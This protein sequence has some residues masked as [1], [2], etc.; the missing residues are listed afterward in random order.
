V[1]PL[2]GSAHRLGRGPHP[3][4]HGPAP[5][6]QGRLIGPGP[7]LQVLP[8]SSHFLHPALHDGPEKFPQGVFGLLGNAGQGTHLL[9]H[10]LHGRVIGPGAGFAPLQHGV[11]QGQLLGDR[12]HFL[13]VLETLADLGADGLF[14]VADVDIIFPQSP[15]IE[16]EDTVHQGLEGLAGVFAHQHRLVPGHVRQ[17]RNLF[18]GQA[19]GQKD[20]HRAHGLLG[21]DAQLFEG[22]HEIIQ[23]LPADP[24]I[25]PQKLHGGAQGLGAGPHHGRGGGEFLERRGQAVNPQGCRRESQGLADALPGGLGHGLETLQRLPGVRQAPLELRGV[26]PQ[27]GD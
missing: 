6:P 7:A 11:Q 15:G 14:Q 8:G 24:G 4:A 5:L 3:L 27:F 21:G 26:R 12:V 1:D 22:V 17:L 19:G 13:E 20:A 16:G 25:F 9:A 2:D 18:Q 10:R 23:G